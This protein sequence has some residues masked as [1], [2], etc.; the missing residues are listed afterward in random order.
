MSRY[1]K[2]PDERQLRLANELGVDN[3]TKYTYHDLKR[4]L[5]LAVK[6]RRLEE[7][8]RFLGVEFRPGVGFNSLQARIDEVV[9]QRF[10]EFNLQPGTKIRLIDYGFGTRDYRREYEVVKIYD[11]SRLVRVRDESG[12]EGNR[13]W[14][15][16]VLSLSDYQPSWREPP[17]DW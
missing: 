14:E 2:L 3:P 16:V 10:P 8:A 4:V 15:T 11:D 1:T 17:R 13:Q 5:D 12:R 7:R 9:D 6:R